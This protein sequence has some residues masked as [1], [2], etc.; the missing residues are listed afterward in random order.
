MADVTEVAALSVVLIFYLPVL[1]FYLRN[2]V[3]EEFCLNVIVI[4]SLL[5]VSTT[6]A[7]IV[8]RYREYLPA[9][10]SSWIAMVSVTNLSLAWY[11]LVYIVISRL[12][13]MTTSSGSKS[14]DFT[15]GTSEIMTVFL[16]LII[17]ATSPFLY[18]AVVK[19]QALLVCFNSDVKA[20]QN[21]TRNADNSCFNAIPYLCLYL[22]VQ[23]II[24]IIIIINRVVLIVLHPYTI[25]KG[26]Q[27][28]HSKRAIKMASGARS[29]VNT[30]SVIFAVVCIGLV[31]E[32]TLKTNGQET[33]G[34]FNEMFKALLGLSILTLCF[35][36]FFLLGVSFL[37]P[38]VGKLC[39]KDCNK[40]NI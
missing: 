2:W 8:L 16:L 3:E 37:G 6:V 35:F 25:Q 10:S 26:T 24:P 9:A 15:S 12:S 1:F 36:P 21:Q 7:A 22:I 20:N 19:V 27:C 4:Q 28:A 30:V 34:F 11:L 33:L 40:V 38:K 31:I 17:A 32:I 23:Y 39:T 29:V 14:H 5:T 13:H 18:Y